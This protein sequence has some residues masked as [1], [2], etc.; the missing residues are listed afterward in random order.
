MSPHRPGS[1][2][3][4]SFFARP[5][6]EVAPDLIGAYLVR[7]GAR[8]RCLGRIVEVEAYLGDGS[9]PGSHSHR[10]PTP[11]NRV[12]F[13]PPGKAYVYRSYGVHICANVVCEEAG[14]GAAVLFRAIEPLEGI[15]LMQARRGLSPQAPRRAIS[16][17][18]GKLCQAF[19]VGME[20]DGRSLLRG[21]LALRAPGRRDP[22]V[23]VATSSRIGLS[24]GNDLPYRFYA[25]GSEWL[26]PGRPGAAPRR[27]RSDDR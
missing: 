14:R 7:T 19:D 26:S 20:F 5:C 22:P 23:D 13:G 6:L 18:P 1:T 8:T 11:R 16:N 9:D 17:G 25:R 10:G 15:E 3:S 4:R 24:R 21:A 12:M 2:F 27:T